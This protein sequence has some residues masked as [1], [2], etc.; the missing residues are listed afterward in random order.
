MLFAESGLVDG[1]AQ[2]RQTIDLRGCVYERVQIGE[3]G[4]KQLIRSIESPVG[5]RYDR[6]PYTQ[7]EKVLRAEG[8]D[9]LANDV[10]LRRQEVER[11]LYW[12]NKQWRKYIR[13]CFHRLV[14][15]GV[16]PVLR[17]ASF[18]AMLLVLGCW[19]FHPND[20][21]IVKNRR[22]E[23]ADEHRRVAW[24][25]WDAAA[26]SV[27]HFCLWMCPWEQDT[28]RRIEAPLAYRG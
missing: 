3:A 27:H 18:A 22:D 10:Y 26:A 2:F 28:C 23:E 7:L 8:H 20:S 9:R 12:Q 13:S 19:V 14:K 1:K 6:Q 21:V 25:T 4:L 24:S 15:Y 16:Q 11:K 17:L 5:G